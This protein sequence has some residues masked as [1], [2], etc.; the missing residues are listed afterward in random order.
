[1]LNK[2][3]KKLDHLTD[4]DRR[5]AVETSQIHYININMKLLNFIFI[6][7]LLAQSNIFKKEAVENNDNM[8]S[9]PHF[10]IFIYYLF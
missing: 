7:K 2:I 1:M 10:T 6:T 3:R 5:S 9:L 4:D 8:K